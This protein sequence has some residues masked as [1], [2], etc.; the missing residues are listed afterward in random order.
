MM[1][2]SRV[3]ATRDTHLCDQRPARAAGFAAEP[4]VVATPRADRSASPTNGELSQSR[5][6]Q[7]APMVLPTAL[8][9]PAADEPGGGGDKTI[10]LAT[11]R[12]PSRPPPPT[13]RADERPSSDTGRRPRFYSRAELRDGTVPCAPPAAPPR[14]P[15]AFAAPAVTRGLSDSELRRRFYSLDELLDRARPEEP[16]A[17]PPEPFFV[18]PRGT[19]APLELP[20]DASVRQ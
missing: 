9:L 16:P 4:K 12:V 20:V 15:V 17:A 14:A 2:P 1:T 10:A 5:A 11:A 6:A 7:L 18:T 3:G 19:V 8:A 13:S